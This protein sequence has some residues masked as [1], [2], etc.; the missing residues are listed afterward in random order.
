VLSSRSSKFHSYSLTSTVQRGGEVKQF[1][2]QMYKGEW[3]ESPLCHRVVIL[4]CVQER[5]KE[6]LGV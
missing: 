4:S 6:S 1:V 2:P 3:K 5:V